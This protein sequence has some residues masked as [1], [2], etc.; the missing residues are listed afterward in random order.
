ME[1]SI[2]VT[3]HNRKKFL[4]DA[5]KS[6]LRQTISR[7]YYEII[8]VKNF[9]DD[10]IDSE[11]KVDNFNVVVSDAETV[12]A[13]ISVALDLAKGDVIVFLEDD[14]VFEPTKLETLRKVFQDPCVGYYHNSYT[15][16]DENGKNTANTLA[17]ST[18]SKPIQIGGVNQSFRDISV[19]NALE[20]PYYLSCIS[21]KS[22]LLKKNVNKIINQQVAVDPFMF[23]IAL[24]SDY[25]LY[26]DNAVLTKRRI[27]SENNSVA[28]D[29][30]FKNF[31]LR[32]KKFLE[33][34]INGYR[35]IRAI[36]QR[37]SI[38]LY[39]EYRIYIGALVLMSITPYSGKLPF[40][41]KKIVTFTLNS[42]LPLLLQLL[43]AYIISKL[44]PGLG[45]AV[46]FLYENRKLHKILYIKNF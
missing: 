24:E 39:S 15:I 45:G 38:V 44:I 46:Y 1:F 4:N 21:I 8:L 26:I 31:I 5:V 13:K 35:I 23:Y 2:I 6:V 17:T 40:P 14:D 20:A 3:A 37:D 27:H 28:S 32:K 19:L 25:T 42:K 41:F 34:T 36:A 30:T 33:G 9:V 10:V 11:L 22:N 29:S 43:T 7:D 16:I 12:G 18:I